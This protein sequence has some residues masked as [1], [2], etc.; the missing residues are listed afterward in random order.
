[1]GA[2]CVHFLAPPAQAEALADPRAR[3]FAF[4]AQGRLHALERDAA[5][6]AWISP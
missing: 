6:Q 3:F 4:D 5:A 1:L 2:L